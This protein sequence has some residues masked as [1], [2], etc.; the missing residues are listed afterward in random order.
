MLRKEQGA[1]KRARCFKK[2]IKCFEPKPWVVTEFGFTDNLFGIKHDFWIMSLFQFFF[3]LDGYVYSAWSRMDPDM[4]GE[5]EDP[6]EYNTIKE[7][8]SRTAS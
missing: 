4:D 2:N 7:L 1:A 5:I 8:Y 3:S 6:E